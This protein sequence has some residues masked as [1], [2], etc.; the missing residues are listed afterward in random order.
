MNLR[1]SEHNKLRV[2]LSLSELEALLAKQELCLLSR[3]GPEFELLFT[4]V[5]TQGKPSVE[6]L[7][8]GH[9]VFRTA[10]DKLQ[11]LFDERKTRQNAYV[12]SFHESGELQVSIELDRFKASSHTTK[13]A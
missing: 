3:I 10:H 2:R 8:N 9:V 13:H 4:L 6:G 11:R 1:F 12:E 7:R 5:A